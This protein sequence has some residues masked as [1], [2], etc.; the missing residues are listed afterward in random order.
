MPVL[1]RRRDEI[2]EPVQELTRREVDNAIG[3]RPGGLSAAAGSDPVGGFV[4]GQHV[5]DLDDA[6]V[7]V[8]DHGEPLKR[9]WRPGA[10]SEKVLKRLALDTHLGR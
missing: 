5:A 10:V 4:S 8:A 3:S 6:A 1:P 2:G 7:G 9:E